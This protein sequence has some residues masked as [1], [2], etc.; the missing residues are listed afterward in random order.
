MGLAQ[1]GWLSKPPGPDDIQTSQKTPGRE[2]A[3]WQR[4]RRRS[5]N[6]LLPAH[7]PCDSSKSRR[8]NKSS[9]QTVIPITFKS[10]L[11][12]ERLAG[13]CLFMSFLILTAIGSRRQTGVCRLLHTE[14]ELAVK[15]QKITDEPELGAPCHSHPA[16]EQKAAFIASAETACQWKIMPPAFCSAASHCPLCCSLPAYRCLLCPAPPIRLR[17]H[18]SHCIECL[19]VNPS[20]S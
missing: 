6:L 16:H 9:G 1:A 14:T 3:P 5:E 20:H 11:I 12:L 17:Q 2:A 8:E 19:C 13:N 4:I 15:E 7:F 18:T 10:G